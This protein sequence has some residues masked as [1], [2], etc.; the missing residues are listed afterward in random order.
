MTATNGAAPP[1]LEG[2]EPPPLMTAAQV[3]ATLTPPVAAK[4]IKRWAVQGVRRLGDGERVRLRFV[5]SG[6]RIFTTTAW[7]REFQAAIDTDGD[8]AS[9]AGPSGHALADA[10][11]RQEGI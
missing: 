4:T 2:D 9:D 10:A 7:V 3:A 11:L 1:V 8:G 6:T 5:R